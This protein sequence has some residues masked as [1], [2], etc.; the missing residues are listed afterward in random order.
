MP[1]T[2]SD[3]R[4]LH[5]CRLRGVSHEG[6]RGTGILHQLPSMLRPLRCVT[7]IQLGLLRRNRIEVP[8]QPLPQL[9]LPGRAVPQGSQQRPDPAPD[10]DVGISH[11]RRSR[12]MAT[13]NQLI[14]RRGQDA[15]IPSCRDQPI[16]QH[17]GR[18][19]LQRSGTPEGQLAPGDTQHRG[20]KAAILQS[21]PQGMLPAQ[22][23]ADAGFGFQIGAVIVILQEHSQDN[24]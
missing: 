11:A 2:G 15:G 3:T 18:A 6:Q 24:E 22:I 19:P 17:P 16:K 8:A 21:K 7:P 13:V 23:E 10:Q 4:F 9:R 20:I 14:R 1:T 12:D 5:R